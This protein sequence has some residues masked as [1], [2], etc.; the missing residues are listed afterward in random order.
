[1]KKYTPCQ[2]AIE[3]AIQ[4]FGIQRDYVTNWFNQLMETAIHVGKA[5][6]RDVYDHK[7]KR[8]IINGTEI[9]TIIRP[10]DIPFNAQIVKTIERE[11]RKA[12]RLHKRLDKEYEVKIA[13]LTIEQA[14]LTLNRLKAKSPKVI[15]AIQTKLEA[16][17][18]ELETLN[19][20]RKGKRDDFDYLKRN[21]HA[22]L[23][24][25]EA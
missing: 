25:Q 7:G 20:E 18:S 23:M 4:R 2:H 14:Q 24:E 13:E 11:M 12:E 1:M 19:V 9:V 3:R 8:I 21:A 22:Y 16:I 6:N 17:V 15:A 5:N 10:K